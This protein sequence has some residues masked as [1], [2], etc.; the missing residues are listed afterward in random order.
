M[1]LIQ[2]VPTLSSTTYGKPF[3]QIPQKELPPGNTGSDVADLICISPLV[4]AGSDTKWLETFHGIHIDGTRRMDAAMMMWGASRQLFDILDKYS[5]AGAVGFLEAFI[6][7]IAALEDLRM[8]GLDL[9]ASQNMVVHCCTK[10]ATE[11]YSDYFTNNTC[12]R[13]TLLHPVKNV[14]P[15]WPVVSPIARSGE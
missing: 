8:V 4:S 14:E 5:Q 7:T 6:P 1:A 2:V 12:L 9:G 13:H 15:F 3:F 11:L 10:D